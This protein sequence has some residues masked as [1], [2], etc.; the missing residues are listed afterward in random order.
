VAV[1]LTLIQTRKV[2]NIKGTIQNKVHTINKV[3]TVQIQTY[4]VIKGHVLVFS[5]HSNKD[6][7]HLNPRVCCREPVAI[8]FTG[9]LKQWLD[10]QRHFDFGNCIIS[11]PKPLITKRH[12]VLFLIP[13]FTVQVMKLVQFT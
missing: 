8:Y 11:V 6:I 12:Y 7:S 4:K 13:V 2:Y 3:H 9:R 1:E 10:K 5:L